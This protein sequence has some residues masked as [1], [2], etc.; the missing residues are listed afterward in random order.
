VG[1]KKKMCASEDE[2]EDEKMCK[3]IAEKEVKG[4]EKRMHKEEQDIEEDVPG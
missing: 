4:D 3:D 2:K 1:L